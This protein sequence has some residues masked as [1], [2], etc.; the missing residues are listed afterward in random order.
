MNKEFHV[1]ALVIENR[2]NGDLQIIQTCN[3]GRDA[4]HYGEA[5]SHFKKEYGFDKY[6]IRDSSCFYINA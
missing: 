2:L 1:V 4:D 5:L 6:N 3:L